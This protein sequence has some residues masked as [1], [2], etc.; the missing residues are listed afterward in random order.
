[1]M[2][3]STG[4]RRA[5]VSSDLRPGRRAI[6]RCWRNHMQGVEP[7]GRWGREESLI[8]EEFNWEEI[9]HISKLG[10]V[11]RGKSEI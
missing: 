6:S 8:M 4:G 5:G 7:E 9:C 3:D 10:R 2:A 11:R 1:M